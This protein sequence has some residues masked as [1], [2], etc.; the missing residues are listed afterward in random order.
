MITSHDDHYAR[1]E[2]PGAVS[3][4]ASVLATARLRNA[5]ARGCASRPHRERHL[6]QVFAKLGV[7]NRVAIAAVAHHSIE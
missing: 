5:V 1:A 3:V 2:A 4:S 7:P 6:R